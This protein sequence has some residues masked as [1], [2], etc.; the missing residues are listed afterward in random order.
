M[1]E[2]V[3]R[4]GRLGQRDGGWLSSKLARLRCVVLRYD[5][6][7]QCVTV[8]YGPRQRSSSVCTR[9]AGFFPRSGSWE[10]DLHMGG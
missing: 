6:S 3:E 8:D 10:L 2:D 4:F 5:A 9:Q 1:P 7:R